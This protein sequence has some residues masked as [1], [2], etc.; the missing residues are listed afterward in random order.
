MSFKISGG[1]IKVYLQNKCSSDI[2]LRIE[3]PDSAN[4]YTVEDGVSKLD[5]FL[6]GTKTFDSKGLVVHI[7]TTSTE[8]KNSIVCE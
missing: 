5:T 7:V 8:E 2:S 3:S 1:R 4:N 6:D